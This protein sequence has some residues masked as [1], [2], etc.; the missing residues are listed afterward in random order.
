MG[1]LLLILFVCLRGYSLFRA[2][3]KVI[4]AYLLAVLGGN[5]CP[6]AND[7]KDI[8]GSG[9]PI[10]GFFFLHFSLDFILLN[11]D[12]IWISIIVNVESCNVAISF[13]ELD[14]FFFIY[15]FVCYILWAFCFASSDSMSGKSLYVP[16]KKR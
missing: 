6:S 12:C 8:L 3:M 5:T 2:E 4:A 9:N 1:L 16:L 13:R 10:F 11:L 15:I 14:R 7:L